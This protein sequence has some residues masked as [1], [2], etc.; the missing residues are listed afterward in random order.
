[1]MVG[2]LA[3]WFRS[4]RRA[5]TRAWR[6][7]CA[8]AHRSGHRRR[9]PT[10][11]L[12]AGEISGCGSV[13]AR[14]GRRP[15]PPPGAA[16][17]PHPVSALGLGA[18]RASATA[19]S[20]SPPGAAVPARS[21]CRASPRA[22]ACGSCAGGRRLPCA[23]RRNPRG[24][25]SCVRQ[26][27]RARRDAEA[28]AASASSASGRQRAQPA[29]D[30]A[31]A[32]GRRNSERAAVVV[33][34]PRPSL[35]RTAP[36]SWRA[37]AEQRVGQRRLAAP[38][39]RAAPACASGSVLRSARA[40]PPRRRA[41]QR[42]D[43]RRPATALAPASACDGTARVRR[44]RCRPCSSTITG[45]TPLPCEREEALHAARV[46]VGVQAHH[47]QRG[48]D[49]GH[50]RVAAPR[51]H[52]GAP[53][54]S[55]AARAACTQ[56]WPCASGAA[57]TR[58]PTA[59]ASSSSASARARRGAHRA[60]IA[61]ALRRAASRSRGAARRAHRRERRRAIELRRA[62]HRLVRE[63]GV[64]PIERRRSKS[65]LHHGDD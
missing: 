57:N 60:G 5:W 21:W 8:A 17:L 62:G 41:H 28:A 39:S 24:A 30:R 1:M 27:G 61:R 3:Q 65:E 51:R 6:C 42:D 40:A 43:L 22:A 56:C 47:E 34:W 32:A 64:S 35:S 55:A 16:P 58:S 29:I 26:C 63:R 37:C 50:H 10:Q 20:T 59:S 18:R 25:C 2:E 52:R 46:E 9:A 7:T 44:P 4:M 13:D 48:V 36:V 12:P 14:P 33:C 54:G 23:P 38:D 49:V 19:P 15:Q 31:G 45:A 11:A 53:G